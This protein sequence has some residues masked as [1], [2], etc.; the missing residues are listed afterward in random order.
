MGTFYIYF[1]F[2]FNNVGNLSEEEPF[3]LASS[4][5]PTGTDPT[6]Q[7]FTFIFIFNN[8]HIWKIILQVALIYSTKTTTQNF[9]VGYGYLTD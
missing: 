4:E 6:R 9:G 8:T 5:K 2:F 7:N 1:F 3:G